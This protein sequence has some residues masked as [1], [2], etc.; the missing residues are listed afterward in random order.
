MNEYASNLNEYIR[1]NLDS[2]RIS[3][4]EVSRLLGVSPTMV[5]YWRNDDMNPNIDR[6][7]GLKKACMLAQLFGVSLE[8]FYN[9]KYSDNINRRTNYDY[10]DFVSDKEHNRDLKIELMSHDVQDNIYNSYISMMKEYY[11]LFDKAIKMD[12]YNHENL[13]RLD[14]ILKPNISGL[15]IFYIIEPENGNFDY[16]CKSFSYDISELT[17]KPE[18]ETLEGMT[19]NN[20]IIGDFL[21][22]SQYDNVKYYHLYLDDSSVFVKDTKGVRAKITIVRFDLNTDN[23]NN[24]NTGIERTIYLINKLN[25][26]GKRYNYHLNLISFI[27]FITSNEIE[28]GLYSEYDK[29]RDIV[30]KYLDHCSAARLN[31]IFSKKVNTL[32]DGFEV[33]TNELYDLVVRNARYL[34]LEKKVWNE[35]ETTMQAYSLVCEAV[36]DNRRYVRRKGAKV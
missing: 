34:N 24:H 29:H 35:S 25:D 36:H 6:K 17:N 16:N 27:N 12:E 18:G 14:K 23:F 10:L 28:S 32:I 19:I 15:E 4:A 33:L 5:A 31:F 20:Y 8:D 26:L 3:N 11:E 7:P 1:V 22:K 9:L 13:I 2:L 21:D 30:K